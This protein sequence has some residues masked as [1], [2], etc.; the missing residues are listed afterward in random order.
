[1][2]FPNDFQI[3]HDNALRYAASKVQLSAQSLCYAVDFFTMRSEIMRS[4]L[5]WLEP[6]SPWQRFGPTLLGLSIIGVGMGGA[7]RIVKAQDT[8]APPPISPKPVVTVAVQSSGDADPTTSQQDRAANR[9]LETLLQQRADLDARIADLREKLRSSNRV[10]ARVRVETRAVAPRVQ[11]DPAGPE[12][13][14][15]VDEARQQARDAMQQARDA[16]R[17]AQEALREAQRATGRVDGNTRSAIPVPPQTKFNFDFKTDP[18]VRVYKMDPEAMKRLQDQLRSLNN[19]NNQEQWAQ[20]WKEMQPQ[21]EQQMR[22]FQQRMQEWQRNFEAQ[23]RDFEAQQRAWQRQMQQQY[24]NGSDT[25]KERS[26]VYRKLQDLK[27]LKRQDESKSSDSGR[28]KSSED[29]GDNE[30]L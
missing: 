27:D 28:Q 14:R 21:F 9:E 29:S 7:I 20:K 11:V 23:Q 1:M 30:P 18:N 26:D 15:A 25:Y 24:R 6:R 2:A 3:L 12:W 8:A 22:E 13:Q 17:Q 10:R 5:P 4:E 19:S 16:M